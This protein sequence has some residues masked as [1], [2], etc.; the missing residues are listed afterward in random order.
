MWKHVN[1]L[2]GR[3]SKTRHFPAFKFGNKVRECWPG[4]L[5]PVFQKDIDYY[6]KPVSVEFKIQDIPTGDVI[7]I[8]SNLNESKSCRQPWQDFCK[9]SSVLAIRLQL[10]PSGAVISNIEVSWDIPPG[11]RIW[12]LSNLDHPV[13]NKRMEPGSFTFD[14]LTHSNWIGWARDLIGFDV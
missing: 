2:V 8:H 6:M 11:T 9:K 14:I 5:K 1:Q 12:W 4:T 7:N 3:I 10:N 13:G